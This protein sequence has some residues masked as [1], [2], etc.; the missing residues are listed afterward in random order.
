MQRLVTSSAAV[1]W[2]LSSTALLPAQTSKETKPAASPVEGTLT[3]SERTYKLSHVVAYETKADDETRVTVIASDR[4]I[5]FDAI[6]KALREGEGSDDGLSLSQPHVMISF[7]KSGKPARCKA[8]ADNGSF[9]MG[10]DSLTGK[11]KLDGGRASGEAK[12]VAK[13]DSPF[14]S[15]FD[16]HWDV[17]LGAEPAAQPAAK[18]AG[19]VKPSVTGTFKGNGKPAKLAFVSARSGEDFA[20][21]PSIVLVFTEKDHSKDKKPDFK[22]GFGEYGS[23]LIISVFEEDGR[24][25]G[26]EVA[27]AAHGKM[28]FSSVGSIR[29]SAFDSGE[30]KVE[31]EIVTDGEVK[32]FDKTW[33]V[34]LKFVAPYTAPPRT[35]VATNDKPAAKEPADKPGTAKPKK[36]SDP[37]DEDDEDATP[38]KG[39]GALNVKDL[40]LPKDA[41][42]VVYKKLVEHMSF[43]S[44]TAVQALANEFSKKLAEQGWKS[45]KGDLINARSAI[46][47]RKHGQASLTIFVKPADKGSTVT[48]MT[49]GLDWEEK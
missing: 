23:A 12:L 24:I 48:I 29:T 46:L 38:A 26:C 37:D 3:V 10:G 6:Q 13:K 41:T 45:D 32:T 9:S 8:W 21:K 25:F 19:P 4:K 2:L 34:D 18:P 5:S 40:A 11:L 35:Q 39:A 7:E 14:K 42:D 1:L 36:K 47:N 22:A 27:H 15:A 44:P 16:F 28:P 31:G 43:K 33:E 30:G 20:D 49:A 17:A